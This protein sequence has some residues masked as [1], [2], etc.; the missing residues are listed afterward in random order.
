MYENNTK[1]EILEIPFDNITMQDCL[2][3]VNVQLKNN[4]KNFIVTANPEIVMLAN[5]DPLYKEVILQ[6]NIIVADGVGI[7]W[8]S[9][10]LNKPLKE[11]VAGVDLMMN[12][13]NIA[14][15][16][17]LSCYF[18]GATEITNKNL[19]ENIERN[20]PQL[21]VAGRHH[22]FANCEQELKI[23][24]EINENRPDFVFVATGAPKQEK[25]IRKNYNL[26]SK[27]IFM[28]VG[29]S[30][31]VLSGQVNR[32]SDFWIRFHLEWFHRILKD[33]RKI[34]KVSKIFKFMLLIIKKHK[35]LT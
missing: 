4:S 32:A 2:D 19:V 26:F 23:I 21:R 15:E 27:G 14:N 12:L 29:G 24:K 25:W 10:K 6:A 8:A 28:G 16:K 30:F 9:K 3:K 7:V 34:K 1:V 11:R 18:F 17:N 22:G 35:Q 20:Y 33:P 5:E 31:D 13:L